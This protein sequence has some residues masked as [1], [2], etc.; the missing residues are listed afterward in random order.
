[1]LSAIQYFSSVVLAV[2]KQCC[3]DNSVYNSY[4]VSADSER[5]TSAS[6]KDKLV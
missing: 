2:R 1:M 4:Y 6:P 5:K 3:D